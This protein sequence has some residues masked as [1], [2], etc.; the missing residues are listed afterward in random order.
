MHSNSKFDGFTG[1]FIL[2]FI[3]FD[4]TA[5]TSPRKPDFRSPLDIPLYLSSNYGEYRSGHFHAGVDFKTQQVENK[6]VYAVDSGYIYRIAVLSAGYGKALY[7]K[8]P[9]GHITLYGHLNQFDKAVEKYVRD[10]QYRKKSFTVDLYPERDKFV[11]RKGDWIGLSG[12]TGM[13]FGAH[14]HFEIRDKSGAI[15]LNPLEYG[16]A[17]SDRTKPE[18]RWLMV[19]PADT[20][21][22]VNGTRL[23]L[24]FKTYNSGRTIKIQPDT[25]DAWGDIGIGIETYDFL[26]HTSNQC[27]PSSVEVK[28][29][30]QPV[31]LCR[32][33]SISFSSGSYIYS[34][35]DY[36]ELLRTGRKIQ[37]LFIDPNNK[38]S[39]YKLAV[40]R[41]ILNMRDSRTHP[42]KITV[43]DTYGNESVLEFILRSVNI[44]A[45]PPAVPDSF[46]VQKF[47]YDSLNVFENQNVRI[48]LPADALFDHIDF[49]YREEKNDS[50]KYSLVHKIHERFTPLMRPYILSLKADGLTDSLR[51][52]ALIASRGK[53]GEWISQG[54]E[55]GR[56]YVTA[57][58]RTF[59]DFIIVVDSVAPSIKPVNFTAGAKYPA[60]KS[61]S[62]SIADSISGIRK[63]SGYIDRNWALFEYD[64]KSDL[65]S[66]TIDPDRLVSGKMHDLEIIVTDNKGN[67]GKFSSAFYY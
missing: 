52:K 9:S 10:Q 20:N 48:V 57:N 25:V 31:F 13:S 37:K 60:G 49:R 47:Y 4:L 40:N 44:I 51:H 65:L 50:F 6:N 61:I 59:G 28:V 58:V 55:Y 64:L 22:F 34:Y 18:I 14:L 23:K 1:L 67:V 54:G 24:P 66:Y 36:D 41:G 19:Y 29:D 33:D 42:V 38:L 43:K 11:Y 5:Q 2:L 26:D 39:V 17:V 45:A 56:G 15:P 21:S 16:F 30:N 62:F 63:Y 3:F 46:V 8:H 32:I 7:I 12:N 53:K 27:G 35:Y